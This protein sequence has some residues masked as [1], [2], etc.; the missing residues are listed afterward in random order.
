MLI[1]SLVGLNRTIS[2]INLPNKGQISNLPLGAMVETN[3]VFEKNHITPVFAGSLPHNIKSLIDPH[4]QNQADILDAGLNF[5]RELALRAFLNDPLMTIS[6]SDGK[7]L[8]EEMLENTKA[9]LPS[10][11]F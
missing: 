2:N 9:Y 1:K 6:E 3:A 5:N 11:W 4:I 7:K 8:F 10:A